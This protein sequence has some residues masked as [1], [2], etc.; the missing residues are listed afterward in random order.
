[1]LAVQESATDSGW[2]PVPDS[3]TL[4]GEFVALLATVTAP[5]TSPADVG[6]NVM[7]SVAVWFGVNTNPAA[8]PLAPNP[9]PVTPTLEIVTFELPLFVSVT[10][11]AVFVPSFTLP[12][13]KVVGLAPSDWVE[14]TPVPL[15]GIA[16]GEPAPLF[17]RETDP[18]SLPAEVGENTAL[19]FTLAPTAIV[20]GA[21]RP[22][23]LNPVPDTLTCE[24]VALAVPVFIRLMVCELVLPATTL[25]KL[26]L[27][28]ADESCASIPVP[29][30][31]TLSGELGALL[32][33]VTLPLALPVAVGAKAALNVAFWPALMVSG[34]VIPLIAKPLPDALA[35]ETTT[36]AVPEFDSV[37]VWDPL[38][39]TRTLPKLTLE[40]LAESCPRIPVPLRG[41]ASGELGPL[42]TSEMDPL[43]VPAEVGANATLNEVL[44]PAATVVG[45][46]RPLMAKPLPDTLACEMVTL[47]DPPFRSVMVCE[48][49]PPA[50][51]FP[52]LTLDGVGESCASIPVPLRATVSGE[53]GALLAMETLPEALPTAV[54]AKVTVTVE[55]CPALTVAG[56]ARPLRLKPAPEALAAEI[57][58]AAFP[59]FVRAMVCDPL[60]PTTIVPKLTLKGLVVSSPCVPVPLRA[61]V[62][63]GLEA[64]LA[65]VTLPAIAPAE[66]GANWIWTVVLWPAGIEDEALPPTIVY[67]VPEMAACEICTAAV[68]E[69]VRVKVSTELLPTVTFPKLTLAGVEESAPAFAFSVFVTGD[70][71][72]PAHP[73]SST[74][75]ATMISAMGASGGHARKTPS[76]IWN[77][78]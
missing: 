66:R 63:V 36:L 39:P 6:S 59:G 74:M 38:L 3:E 18:L 49:V 68:P 51:T 67:P 40:V 65:T 70:P 28:G 32:V 48:L 44:A 57:V 9:A 60:V 54:G 61:I 53:P 8:T 27:D 42:L 77:N 47:A 26:T 55:L 33:T 34:V 43:T 73:E 1:V 22:L 2:I 56:R 62:S 25:P 30:R 10:L 12:K 29:L 78:G 23:V 11:C 64:S 50:A 71:A 24:I 5:V 76:S 19:N 13:L 72:M 20:I 46:E 58:R 7:L 69:F 16:S 21:E 45:V 41:M 17:T 15:S 75:V 52:K 4:V 35:A 37:I 14:A 31:A